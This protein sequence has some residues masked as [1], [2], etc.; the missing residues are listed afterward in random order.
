M[1]F[2][3]HFRYA[4]N[5][6]KEYD[7]S[8]P[9]AIYLK[10]FFKSNK[11]MGSRDRKTVSGLVYGYFRLGHLRFN[12]I[13]E[14]IQAG[15]DKNVSAD[16]IFPFKHLLS[17]G[18]DANV[19]ETSFLVQPDL[20]IRVR[21]GKE[22]TVKEKLSAAGLEFYECGDNCLGMPN[23]SKVDT[24]LQLNKEA[25]IQDK[26]SQETGKLI[27]DL[28]IDNAWDCCAA[29]G[30]KSLMVHDLI[31]KINLTVS[32]VRSS[33]INNL[34]ERFSRAGISSY[35][36]FV[37]DLTDKND[38]LPKEKYDL[39]IADVPCT[40]SGTWLRTPEQL[41]FF[42]EEKVDYYQQLQQKI[43]S[44]VVPSMKQ[45]GYLLY[46][47]CSVFKKENEDMLEFIEEEFSLEPVKINLIKGYSD[48]A[49]TLFSAL[50]KKQ[51]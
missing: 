34:K 30:G 15:I 49:D 10:A 27:K 4:A 22:K 20:F 32:D 50:Y 18:L 42:K 48:K 12:N 1:I 41:C 21:P 5:I 31:K 33:I 39:I 36:S 9:L 2:P 47:T 6:I 43:V 37:A 35:K 45:G 40:G 44:R 7:G 14:R 17:E 16:G 46:I 38:N 19:F 13:E 3:N 23:S 26:S 25:V 11:Q 8:V 29:S 28:S 24:I 51:T